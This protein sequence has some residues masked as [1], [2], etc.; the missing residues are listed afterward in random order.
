M[1]RHPENS[2]I[3]LAKTRAE[4]AMARAEIARLEAELTELRENPPPA[5][6]GSALLGELT[7][8]KINELIKHAGESGNRSTTTDCEN[9]A[10]QIIPGRKKMSIS[11]LFKWNQTIGVNKYRSRCISLGL[12]RNV[13]IDQAREEALRYR[14]MLHKHKDPQ[15]E[16]EKAICDEH[17]ARESFR[18]VNQV[19]DEWFNAKIK[20]KSISTRRKVEALLRDHVRG[21]IGNMPIDKVTRN[22]I[23]DILF[24]QDESHPHPRFWETHHKSADELL[25][26]LRCMWSFA[27]S[28]GYKFRA[29]AKIPRYGSMD[30]RTCFPR[31]RMCTRSRTIPRCLIKMCRTSSSYCATGAITGPGMCLVSRVVRSRHMRSKC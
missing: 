19:A 8:A 5:R 22:H 13:S 15:I 23:V 24:S 2:Q 17:N 29:T 18:T 14:Q 31:A 9:L 7:P 1:R 3:E 16:R 30:W 11:W 21:V 27:K 20:R 4:L 28:K 26:Y 12:Y 6:R 25:S 10:L